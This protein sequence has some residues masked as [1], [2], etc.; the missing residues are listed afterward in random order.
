MKCISLLFFHLLLAA[1][2][3][4]P[5]VVAKEA[6]AV[7]EKD[8]EN[9]PEKP[10][11]QAFPAEPD[12]HRNGGE[13][14]SQRDSKCKEAGFSLYDDQW[15]LNHWGDQIRNPMS[16][17]S[18][19]NHSCKSASINAR[20]TYN[21]HLVPC[22]FK[23]YQ[24]EKETDGD[25]GPFTM[26]TACQDA[27]PMK[28]NDEI[29]EY[30]VKWPDECVADFN[31]CYMIERDEKILLR[32]ICRYEWTLPEGATHVSVDCTADKE[33]KEERLKKKNKDDRKPFN[34]P[35]V[36]HKYDYQKQRRE[37]YAV[38]LFAIGFVLL[39]VCASLFCTYQYAVKPY[40]IMTADM[41]M[42]MKRS[43]SDSEL[44]SLTTR[45]EKEEMD[46]DTGV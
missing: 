12:P 29:E 19:K 32:H 42:N 21:S 33:E 18:M 25:L 35:I 16:T 14:K 5:V 2:S 39:V 10:M 9:V 6:A 24:I 22:T 45:T 8:K 11:M 40:L 43:K 36:E 15:E 31:R 4:L 27:T 26:S 17:V 28:G 30:V 41:M 13:T 44:N 20:G 34:P 1:V 3:C 46:S 23:F 37:Y 7:E 38:Q